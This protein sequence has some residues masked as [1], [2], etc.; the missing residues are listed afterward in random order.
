MEEE[1]GKRDYLASTYMQGMAPT[2][3]AAGGPV[4]PVKDFSGPSPTLTLTPD[5]ATTPENHRKT[6][7]RRGWQEVEDE[8]ALISDAVDPVVT[9]QRG[10]RLSSPRQPRGQSGRPAHAS[11]TC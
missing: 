4:Q 7:L 5:T 3:I 9:A 2:G 6:D 1:K 11:T 8:G 10:R